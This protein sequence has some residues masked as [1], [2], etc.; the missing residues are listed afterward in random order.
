V[1]D[2]ITL[3]AEKNTFKYSMYQKQ[4]SSDKLS[5]VNKNKIEPY[6]IDLLHSG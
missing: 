3:C 2:R 6:V 5:D 4:I 1:S